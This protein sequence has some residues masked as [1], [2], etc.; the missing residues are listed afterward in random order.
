MILGFTREMRELLRANGHLQGAGKGTGASLDLYPVLKV[1]A[2]D[3][4][5]T[6]LF[7]ELDPA[8][9]DT[10]FG[11]CDLGL[12]TPE[13]GYASLRELHEA[14]GRLGCRL[15][16][17]LYFRARQPLSGYARD[18]RDIGRIRV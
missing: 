12:G 2:P 16:V 14:R 7:S 13:L 6:F 3:G 5:A 10:L 15:E 17:D 11:L 18:A 1:F 9:G 4:G 8:D